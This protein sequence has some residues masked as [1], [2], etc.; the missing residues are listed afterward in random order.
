MKKKKEPFKFLFVRIKNYFLCKKYPFIRARNV[1]TGKPCGYGFTWYD[2]IPTGW[3]IAFGKQF[4]KEL[5]QCLKKNHELKDFRFHQIK[6][7][8]GE[9]CLYCGG[10]T[11]ETLALLHKYEMLSTK[12][13]IYCG[14]PSEYETQ[15]WIE[16]LCEDCFVKYE[17]NHPY[18][19]FENDEE[20]EKYKEERKIK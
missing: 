20:I 12:Y 14:K 9:L 6:E 13:C 1:W 15:G 18:R 7:K 8:F 16:Y 3:R 2:E 4:L 11:E 5:K 17:I 10:A 19:H